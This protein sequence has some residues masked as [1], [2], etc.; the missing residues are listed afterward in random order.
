MAASPAN[1]TPA[2]LMWPCQGSVSTVT[3]SSATASQV[4]ARAL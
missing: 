1:A 2:A 4:K 3:P